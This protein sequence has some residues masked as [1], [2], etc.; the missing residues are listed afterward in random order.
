ME[1]QEIKVGDFSLINGGTVKGSDYTCLVSIPDQI[2]ACGKCP[3]IT[4]MG[5]DFFL[6]CPDCL[7]ETQYRSDNPE[8]KKD[9]FGITHI[10]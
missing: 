4:F 9:S 1:A 5:Y 3:E 2:T 10:K 7:A 6:D 8:T